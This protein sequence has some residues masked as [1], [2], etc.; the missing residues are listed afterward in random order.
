[1]SFIV[2]KRKHLTLLF[3]VRYNLL[4]AVQHCLQFGEAETIDVWLLQVLLKSFSSGLIV[5][6]SY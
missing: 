3:I 2:G 5:V 1:M 4:S 6:L